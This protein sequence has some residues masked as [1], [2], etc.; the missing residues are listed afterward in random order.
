MTKK[1]NLP[2]D[3]TGGNKTIR[4]EADTITFETSGSCTFTGFDFTGG[5]GS[6]Y[7][8]PGFSNKTPSNGVGASVSYT[9]DGTTIPDAGYPF[10]Y[11]TNTSPRLGNGTGTI[12]NG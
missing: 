2:C 9:Y 10:E 3:G 11:T 12:K 8:P 7:C 1:V 6:G 5:S 4:K